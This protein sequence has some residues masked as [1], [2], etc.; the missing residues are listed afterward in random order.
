MLLRSWRRKRQLREFVQSADPT[1]LAQERAALLRE[2]AEARDL[3]S[4]P[5]LP[6]DVEGGMLSASRRFYFGRGYGTPALKPT[7]SSFKVRGLIEPEESSKP[8]D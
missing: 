4:G 3:K 1:I 8:R 5:L 7:D 2:N 6:T